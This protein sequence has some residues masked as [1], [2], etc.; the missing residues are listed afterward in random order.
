MLHI[1]YVLLHMWYLY[2]TSLDS[3]A[4]EIGNNLKKQKTPYGKQMEAQTN[5]QYYWFWCQF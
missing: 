3:F 4:F 2:R 1:L 5:F